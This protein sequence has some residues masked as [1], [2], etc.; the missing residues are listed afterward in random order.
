MTSKH[1]SVPDLDVLS[2]SDSDTRTRALATLEQEARRRLA[3]VET[4]SD[5]WFLQIGAAL[6]HGDSLAGSEFG[7]ELLLLVAQWAYKEGKSNEGM[8]AARKALDLSLAAKAPSLQRRAWSHIGIL[9]F[10]L[11]NFSDASICFAKALEIASSQGDRAGK[12]GAIA[13]LAAARLEAGLID[14]SI[15][16]N[17]YV[18]SLASGVEEL[19][20]LSTEAHH[21]IALASLFL[22]DLDTAV[23]HTNA[24]I[25]LLLET[26]NAF[27]G[28]SRVMME[29]T[30]AKVLIKANDLSRA[31]ERVLA[32]TNYADKVHS[33]PARIHCELARALY[34]AASGKIDVAFTRLAAVEQGI[35]ST[36][37][38]F[39]DFLEVELMCHRYAGKEDFAR[40]Y[41]KKHLS[42]LAEYQRNT[43]NARIAL[44]K[45]SLVASES[46]DLRSQLEAL[47]I[48]IEQREEPTGRH[49]ARVGRIAR[50]LAVASGYRQQDATVLE[51]AARLHDIGKLAIPDAILSKR[52]ELSATETKIVRRHTTEG[53]QLLTDIL[54]IAA[55]RK[56]PDYE[57]LRQA[58]DIALHHHENWDGSGYPRRIAGE[59]IPLAAR[60]VAIA[61]TFDEL[62]YRRPYKAAVSHRD[63]VR[64]IISSAG[65]QFDP[66]LTEFLPRIADAFGD[67]PL[68][69]IGDSP[70]EIA[71][72]LIERI[73]TSSELAVDKT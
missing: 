29:F 64:R 39:R 15:R 28:L 73:L 55:E 42:N 11:R 58:A 50:E 1:E 56:A 16:L 46:R 31:Q 7:I 40:Y 12:C 54:A 8:P 59:A 14:E 52:D 26:N 63:A 41:N 37:A 34:E 68:G 66:Q 13:N 32:A 43:A 60:I 65:Q 25:Q 10:G 49:A 27:L 72:R 57:V 70:F 45:Q 30:F 21:N 44:I 5:D 35:K 36:D 38:A 67:E 9:N 48:L 69:D 71:N 33:R 53:C 18:V 19:R 3:S 2:S 61:D 51:V 20:R 62:T 24:A 47:S 22:G 4:S 17:Q 23:L 6:L